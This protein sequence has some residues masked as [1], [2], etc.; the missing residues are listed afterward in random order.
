MNQYAPYKEEYET[1]EQKANRVKIQREVTARNRRKR[2][3]ATAF[4]IMEDA[5]PMT[6]VTGIEDFKV[7]QSSDG[8]S[9]TLVINFKSIPNN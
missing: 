9:G 1:T 5:A 4:K 8:K 6:I 3:F 7:T 2:V